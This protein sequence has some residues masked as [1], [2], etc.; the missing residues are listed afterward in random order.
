MEKSTNSHTRSVPA[1]E[2]NHP[3][4]VV[5]DRL[6]AVVKRLGRSKTSI[7]RDIA[8]GA[9]PRPIR[10]GLRAIGFV[11]AEIDDWLAQRVAQRGDQD[12]AL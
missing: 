8:A 2:T 10:L 7:Y 12:G 3:S 6:P 1:A 9:F 5:I 4:V 11:R